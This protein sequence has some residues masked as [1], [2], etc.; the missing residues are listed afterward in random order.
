MFQKFAQLRVKGLALL[1]AAAVILLPLAA[2]AKVVGY[3]TKGSDDELYEFEVNELVRAFVFSSPSSPHPLYAEFLRGETK[4]LL[5]DVNGYV[6]YYQTVRAFVFSTGNFDLDTYTSGPDAHIVPVERVNVVTVDNGKLVITEK[7]V[8]DPVATALDEVNAAADEISLRAILEDKADILEMNL[9]SYNNLSDYGKTLAA[10]GILVR[11]GEGFADV[12][13]LK[14]AFVAE[15][16]ELLDNPLIVVLHQANSVEDAYSLRSVLE[17]NAGLLGLD[18]SGYNSLSDNGKTLAAARV[19]EHRGDGFA[20]AAALKAVFADQVQAL[21]DNPEIVVLYEINIAPDA[22]VLRSLLENEADVL[23]LDLS[24]YNQ[25]SDYGK[26]VAV[27][28]IL[29]RR[30]DGF[31]TV[32]ELI[33]AFGEEVHN[34]QSSVEEPLQNINSAAGLE[35]LEQLLLEHGVDFNLELDAYNL[36]IASR[37]HYV[38]SQVME[39]RPYETVPMLQQVFRDAVAATLTSYVVVAHTDYEYTIT[40]MVAIQMGLS[41]KPQWHTSSGWRNA[42]ADEVRSYVD[43]ANFIPEVLIDHVTEIIVAYDHLRIRDMPTTQGEILGSV[44]SGQIYAVEGVEAVWEGTNPGTEGYWFKITAGDITGWVCGRFAHWVAEDYAPAMFQFLHLSGPSGATVSDLGLILDGKGIL[45]GMEEV[46]YQAARDNNINEIFLASL[47]LHETGNGTSTLANG[48]EFTPDDPDLE[49]RVVYNMFGIGA[50]D[51]DPIY[52]GA[53]RAY[54]EGWFT[55]EAAIRGGA[56][57]A[58]NSYVN[59]ASY[60]QDTLYKMRWNPGNPG[61]HQ[62]ATDVRWASNQTSFIRPFYNL[63]NIYNLRFDIPRYQ[64]ED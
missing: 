9:S 48:V 28:N 45:S 8:I 20:G 18:I 41:A 39:S 23:E 54:N 49:P 19:L 44:H 64:P 3:V 55:P 60:R 5:D 34:A 36:I 15:V 21:L 59:H 11:R 42:T 16:Q 24:E 25:L 14:A 17:G 38:L 43:P 33:A 56:R 40:D 7:I 4:Y 57:F 30:G 62:Y 1:V 58:S 35:E 29:Q 31:A 47:S 22:A 52:Y 13:E 6:D 12:E 10:A 63:V 27:N 46:F 26:T 51:A 37:K 32:P 53:R 61:V 50:W 2:E